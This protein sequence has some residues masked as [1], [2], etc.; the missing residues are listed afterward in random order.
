MFRALVLSVVVV[1]PACVLLGSEPATLPDIAFDVQTRWRQAFP[2]D[3]PFYAEKYP[4]GTLH[5]IYGRDVGVLH[6]TAALVWES[7][8]RKALASYNHGVIQDALRIWGTDRKPVLYA[9][10]KAGKQHGTTCLYSGGYPWLVQTWKAGEL[11]GES[12]GQQGANTWKPVDDATV[13]EAAKKQLDAVQADWKENEREV[14]K[15]VHQWVSETDENIR[16]QNV[17][18]L[19]PARELRRKAISAAQHK[20]AAEAAR[21][22]DAMAARSHR[23][24]VNAGSRHPVRDARVAGAAKAAAN[25]DARAS[26]AAGSEMKAANQ[27]T[28]AAAKEARRAGQRRDAMLAKD[29]NE[30][31]R[32]AVESLQKAW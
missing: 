8:S 26:H 21:K 23:A 4:S 24:A 19:K 20:E 31:H 25:S 15:E 9:E 14:R 7:G 1:A 11:V 5:G 6:G 3:A 16:K 29:L 17:E 27:A 28:G 30:L 22:S 13:L 18:L 2:A 10:Y 32:F 12:V